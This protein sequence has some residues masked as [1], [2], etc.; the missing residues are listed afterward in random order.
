MNE[1][2]LVIDFGGQ[3]NQLIARRVRENSVYS[4]VI[5]H[6]KAE[7]LIKENIYTSN[8]D[9]TNTKKETKFI[10]KGVILSG[11]G[12]SIYKKNSPK[13]S[14]EFFLNLVKFDIPILGICYGMQALSFAFGG[15][16]KQGIVG[17]YG[18][19]KISKTLSAK[20]S[21]LYLGINTLNECFMSHRDI[22]SK[23][24]KN[25]VITSKTK[26]TNVGSFEDKKNNIY[27]VQYHPEVTHTP[28]GKKIFENYLFNICRCQKSWTMEKYAQNLIEHYK[29]ILKG[30]KVLC[31]L[32]GGVDSTVS[33][34]L[35]SK[36]IK[37][38][39]H[40]IFVDT[41]LLRKNEA[42]EVMSVY[43]KELKLNVK[44]VDAS[45]NFLL[46]L[47]GVTNPE[48]KR[49]IIGTEFIE[50]FNSEAKKIGVNE[51]KISY[52]LQGTIYPDVVESGMGGVSKVIKSHHNVGGLPKKMDLKLL[53]PLRLLF[54]DE[55]RKLGLSLGISKKLVLRQPFPGPGLAI[56][57]IGEVTK[58]K[59][60]IL[61]NADLIVREEIDKYNNNF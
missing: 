59:L 7:K 44:K 3:Y 15:T 4:E 54:K 51:G 48:K 37:N 14:K 24:P 12:D 6:K 60:E 38:D 10:I 31:A 19:T 21:K 8:L 50:V 5:S 52:L 26:H 11:G 41:G 55:V 34:Y 23:I 30:K 17:E 16:V 2:V 32:S 45:K 33:A 9:I 53:E 29:K 25:F 39:L 36:A 58:E 13:L 35:L 43:K 1:I 56:R 20:N 42:T 61:R 57:I 18:N 28:F 46:K 47:K 27:A 40:C 22:T 49:K